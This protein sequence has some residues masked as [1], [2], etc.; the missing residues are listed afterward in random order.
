MDSKTQ[1]HIKF[2]KNCLDD[3]LKG[4]KTQDDLWG[5]NGVITQL[6]KALIERMLNAEMDYHLNDKN[7]GRKVGN[8]RNGHGKKTV[9]SNSGTI[10]ILTP[11]DRQSTFEPQIIPK[12]TTRLENFDNAILSLYA[13]GMTVRDIQDTLKDLY[14]VEV[15]PSLISTVTD[16]VN[17]EVE[18]WRDRPLESVYPVVWLDGT[19]VKV[20]QD[21][22]ILNK[23]VYLAMGIGWNGYKELLGIWIAENEG[24]KFWAQVLAELN[25]RG[26]KDVGIFCVDGLTGFPQAIEG[27][28]PKAD[29]QLCMVHMV[30][31]SLKYVSCK[32]SKAVARD[33]KEIYQAGTLEGAEAALLRFEEQWK[34]K[35]PAVSELWIRHWENV[36]PIFSYPAEIRKVIYTTNAIESLNSAI[37]KRIKGHRIFSSDES[38]IK[39]VWLAVVQAS[40]K[41]TMPLRDWK[42][43][44]NYFYVKFM[45][46]FSL[47]A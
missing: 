3:I 43:A 8:S 4:V 2:D 34:K 29:V 16:A 31:N 45:D 20:H 11:R 46:R 21:H 26:I 37:K 42:K 47:V 22:Q 18:Q 25:N 13:K 10:E 33:L 36:I 41:W 40:K 39:A 6:S 5:E 9:K 35:Y 27:V 32:D 7:T 38:A 19:V 17:E 14:H 1:E 24:A 15:S 23:T 28:F 44:L 12:R 30:R